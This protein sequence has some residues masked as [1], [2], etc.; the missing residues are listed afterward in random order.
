MKISIIT[1][2]WNRADT[3]RDTIESILSQTYQDWEH[4]IVDGAST[5]NTLEVIKSYEERYNGRLK[6]I[7]EPDKGIYDAMNKGIAMATGDV[8]GLLNSDDFLYSDDVLA[9]IATTFVKYN[10]DAVHAGV[11]VINPDTSDVIRV[12]RGSDRP[13]GGM[14]SGWHPA[15]PTLYLKRSV[16]DRFGLFDLQFGTACDMELM[17]RFIEKHHISLK[18]IPRIFVTMRFGGA[19]NNSIGALL[20][21]NRYVLSAFEKNGLRKPKLY[22]LKKLG[23]KLW[24]MV[25]VKLHLVTTDTL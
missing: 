1:A 21:S 20:R 5:D 12:K 15:H 3:I 18:H 6:L 24:N 7:S 9:N 19:S 17:I 14:S 10:P 22:L 16:Y 8:V 25:L 11:T 4:I 13:R 2:T 23:P